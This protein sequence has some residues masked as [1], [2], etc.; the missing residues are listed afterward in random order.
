MPILDRHTFEFTTRSPEQTR[1]LGM[2]LGAQLK[3]GDVF[4]LSGDLGAGK[5]TFV[6]GLVQGWGS[7]DAVTSPTFV[8]VNQY[9]RLDQSI[10]HHLD[11]YRLNDAAEAEALDI[12]HLL[13]TGALIVEW[14]EKI[15]GALPQN[16][17]WVEMKW[18]ADEV[19]YMV[20]QPRGERFIKMI[21]D[22]R[23]SA[24]GG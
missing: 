18:I 24:F 22:F 12:T 9:H 11:A 15:T 7:Y 21:S 14:P 1:R 6:Q 3:K 17:L 19:R 16:C 20:F 13:E 10:I 5:T 8:L 23:R 4:C 2:R